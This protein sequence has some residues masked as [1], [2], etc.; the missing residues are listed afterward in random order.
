MLLFKWTYYPNIKHYNYEKN[1]VL[2][3]DWLDEPAMGWS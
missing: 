2:T 3:N 1:I